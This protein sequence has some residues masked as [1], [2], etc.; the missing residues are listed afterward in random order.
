MIIN[1]EHVETNLRAAWEHEDDK[2]EMNVVLQG[3]ER[4]FWKGTEAGWMGAMIFLG[5]PGQGMGRYTRVSW[6][7]EVSAF[8]DLVVTSKYEWDA[9]RREPAH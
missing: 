8:K 4:N 6:E 5:R 2:D 9:R 7:Q 1:S 3:L